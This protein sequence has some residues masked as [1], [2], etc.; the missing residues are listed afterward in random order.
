MTTLVNKDL[1]TP[2]NN[3]TILKLKGFFLRSTNEQAVAASAT[4]VCARLAPVPQDMDIQDLWFMASEP[5]AAT[6][7]MTIDVQVK[8]AA[9]G[10]FASILSVVFTYQH[11]QGAVPATGAGGGKQFSLMG[12]VTNVHLFAGDVVE[13]IRVLTNGSTIVETVVVVEPA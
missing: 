7:T 1:H 5:A 2:F 11:A 10:G 4:S 6:E 3:K 12:L 9:G 13:V 8:R